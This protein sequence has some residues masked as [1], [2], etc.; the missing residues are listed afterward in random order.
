MENFAGEEEPPDSFRVSAADGV[1]L[2]NIFYIPMPRT[3]IAGS[4]KNISEIDQSSH[5]NKVY[6]GDVRYQPGGSCGPREQRD[7][8]LVII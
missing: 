2:M 7:F 3:N 1:M 8:Q 4:I 6:F 5:F